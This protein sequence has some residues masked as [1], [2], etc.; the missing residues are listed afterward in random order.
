MHTKRFPTFFKIWV[1][2]RVG[3]IPRLPNL[4]LGKLRP[5]LNNKCDT[6][7]RVEFNLLHLY[8]QLPCLLGRGDHIIINRSKTTSF[9]KKRKQILK[10]FSL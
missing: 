6:Y 3:A 9:E 10:T 2:S 4:T 1:Q 7:P 5:F 8:Y